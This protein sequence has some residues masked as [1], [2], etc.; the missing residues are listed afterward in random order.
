MAGL[1]H[2]PTA[3]LQAWMDDYNRGRG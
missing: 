1:K 2:G 3:E